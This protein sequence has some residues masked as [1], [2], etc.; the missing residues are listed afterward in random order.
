MPTDSFPDEVLKF[1]QTEVRHAG[2]ILLDFYDKPSGIKEK[3]D[4]TPVS[5]ADKASSDYLH[6]RIAQAFPNAGI[7]DEERS[8]STSGLQ[9]EYCFVIDPLDGTKDYLRKGDA[10]SVFVGVLHNN[11]P[12]IGVTY[13]PRLNELAY[14]IRGRG[15]H[16]TDN[17][18]TRKL[19]VRPLQDLAVL[20]TNSRYEQLE[21][22]IAKVQPDKITKLSSST[23]IIEVAKG[24]AD[25]FLCA[26]ETTMHMWD[27]CAPGL[28]L[29]EAGGII[30][31]L[32][33]KP[34]TCTPKDIQN[35]T[36]IIAASP[37][38]HKLILQ[39]LRT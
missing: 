25:A 1:L 26:K 15:A 28:I 4:G 12:V 13:R 3:H 30:T 36:G 21:G 18:G 19:S 22:I 31:D 5:D 8:Q 29:E 16:L 24:N 6:S 37:E 35:D 33:G 9:K 10:F 7:F 27:L 34:F 2:K 14:A 38:A 39:R 32:D 17:N 23:K 11:V 20:V